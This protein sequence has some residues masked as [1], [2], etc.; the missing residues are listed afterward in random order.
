MLNEVRHEKRDEPDKD[1][2]LLHSNF[3]KHSAMTLSTGRTLTGSSP[4]RT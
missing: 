1:A 3:R 2:G 4:G